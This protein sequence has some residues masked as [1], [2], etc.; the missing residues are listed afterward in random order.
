MNNSGS[1]TVALIKDKP[2][3]EKWLFTPDQLQ[4]TPSRKDKVTAEK[5]LNYRQQAANLIQDMGQRLPV[6][7]LTI[8]TAIVYMHRF[9][10]FHS[11]QAFSR[12]AMAPTALFLAAKVEE[13]PRKLEHVI[14]VCHSCLHPDKPH[15]DVHSD[16]YLK[17]AQQLVQH[18]LIMLQTLGF[19]ISIDHPHTHVVKCTQLVKASRDLSQMAYFMAT[20]SLHLTTFCLK[21]KPTVVSAMCIH[22]S[23][24]WSNYE[25]PLSSTGRAYWTYMDSTITEAMLENIIKEFLDIL[26]LCPTRL[27]KLKNYKPSSRDGGGGSTPQSKDGQQLK[28]STSKGY[29]PGPHSA[30]VPHSSLESRTTISNQ[31]QS[32]Q[33]KKPTA[34]LSLAEYKNKREKELQSKQSILPSENLSKVYNQREVRDTLAPHHSHQPAISSQKHLHQRHGQIDNSTKSDKTCSGLRALLTESESG[35]QPVKMQST[36]ANHHLKPEKKQHTPQRP[37]SVPSAILGLKKPKHST[38]QVSK[39]SL[40]YKGHL[41]N[42]HQQVHRKQHSNKRP[43][44]SVVQHRSESNSAIS[45]DCNTDLPNDDTSLA[46]VEQ[47]ILEQMMAEKPLVTET[48]TSSQER[49]S[50]P[51]VKHPTPA[52]KQSTQSTT[53]S[54]PPLKDNKIQPGVFIPNKEQMPGH[55]SRQGKS[56]YKVMYQ[57][58]KKNPDALWHQLKTK[59]QSEPL[60]DEEKLILHKL[61]KKEEDRQKK[62]RRHHKH[63]S[64]RSQPI[65]SAS[66]KEG[67]DVTTGG[68]LL[69]VRIKLPA[70]VRAEISKDQPDSRSVPGSSSGSSSEV[71]ISSPSGVISKSGRKRT[72]GLDAGGTSDPISAKHSRKSDGHRHQSHHS[73]SH[74][75]TRNKVRHGKPSS[76]P[77]ANHHK[78]QHGQKIDNATFQQALVDAV[79]LVQS[80]QTAPGRSG[81]TDKVVPTVTLKR[82]GAQNGNGD[83]IAQSSS[84]SEHR[85]S[86][87]IGFD[88]STPVSELPPDN[89]FDTDVDDNPKQSE[90]QLLSPESGEI[91]DDD[92]QTITSARD[93]VFEQSY[94]S[95]ESY[96]QHQ[97]RVNPNNNNPQSMYHQ[98][99]SITNSDGHPPS[100]FSDGRENNESR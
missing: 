82:T 89:I 44:D 83:Y 37:P 1:D 76:P 98:W 28:L 75:S 13:Q 40:H 54:I 39:D 32:E 55:M 26:N 16:T 99:P 27:R 15:L 6:N 66:N 74:K 79:S 60:T 91:R 56:S 90:R 34:S 61:K 42:T 30:Q 8:N 51:A 69:T 5:E 12:F 14:R 24:K 11:F 9:Y 80:G 62:E 33:Q 41:Q 96:L 68:G 31:S 20:N 48:A 4:N 87:R 7:Q 71:A 3:G 38:S 46:G 85:L 10:M 73:F 84:H 53:P 67:G 63:R 49:H 36:S 57:Q 95:K 35:K 43:K 100:S 50:A 86:K 59:A 18:E 70:S 94:K 17:Q 47:K 45:S 78:S 21:Y 29:Q 72:H 97:Q 25:I 52:A 23:C 92:I 19:D 81:S 93:Q 22:L 65:E 2:L 58:Y 77:Q 88:S 64:N